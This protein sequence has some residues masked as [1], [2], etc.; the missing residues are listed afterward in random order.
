MHV[1]ATDIRARMRSLPNETLERIAAGETLDY[2]EDAVAAAREEL[3]LRPVAGATADPLVSPEIPGWSPGQSV[4]A[5]ASIILTWIG[6]AGVIGAIRLLLSVTGVM[7]ALVFSGVAALAFWLA[8]RV[9]TS[10]RRLLTVVPLAFG[11]IFL[12]R[13]VLSGNE[14]HWFAVIVLLGGS[15]SVATFR[16]VRNRKLVA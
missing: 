9:S 7:Y 13:A 5:L 15:L 3:T 12:M 14:D 10:S 8:R 1:T 11:T 16:R 2:T 6:W 4:R